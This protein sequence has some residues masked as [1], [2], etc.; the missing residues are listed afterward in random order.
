M[1]RRG[2]NWRNVEHVQEDVI[3]EDVIEDVIED[4]AEED[5]L[6]HKHEDGTAHSHEGGD[7]LHEHEENLDEEGEKD[8]DVSDS[9]DSGNGPNPWVWGDQSA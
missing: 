1:N 7:E 8:H 4:I 5:E 9:A 2:R 6:L 3:I